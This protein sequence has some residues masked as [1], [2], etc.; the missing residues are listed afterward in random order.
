[1]QNDSSEHYITKFTSI[2]TFLSKNVCVNK[3]SLIAVELNNNIHKTIKIKPVVVELD[4][5]FNTDNHDNTEKLY[6]E[7]T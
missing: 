7:K 3:L 5:Y 2:Y 6:L 1:M 4:T